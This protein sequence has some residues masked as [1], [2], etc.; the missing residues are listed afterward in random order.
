M[1]AWITLLVLGLGLVSGCPRRDPTPKPAPA[2]PPIVRNV[3]MPPQPPVGPIQHSPATTKPGLSG[4]GDIVTVDG[5]PNAYRSVSI[6][7]SDASGT[8]HVGEIEGSSKP[9]DCII[10]FSRPA[11][12]PPT[13]SVTTPGHLQLAADTLVDRLTIHG[14]IQGADLIYVC[15]P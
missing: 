8:V 10:L 3:S 1:K 9:R 6:T 7:G 15:S 5:K 14:V 12:K 4:C 11:Q 13:C 2:P